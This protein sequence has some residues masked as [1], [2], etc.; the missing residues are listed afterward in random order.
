MVSLNENILI[1]WKMDMLDFM[2]GRAI[3]LCFWYDI[4]LNVLDVA[5]LLQKYNIK[6][7][8]NIDIHTDI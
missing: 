5:E 8:Q 6:K 7:K 1:E 4:R 2:L 3:F